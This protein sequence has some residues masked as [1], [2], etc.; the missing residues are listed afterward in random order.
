MDPEISVIF[1]ASRPPG[2]PQLKLKVKLLEEY[3]RK[4][5]PSNES[6]INRIW[7]LRTEQN[8]K[9]YNGSKFRFHSLEIDNNNG[10]VTFGL[11]LT[12]Y[13]D[14]IGTNWADNAAELL[15]SGRR[16]F[17]NSQA[18][19]SDALGVGAFVQTADDCVIFMRRSQHVGEAQGLW[20][21]PGGHAEPG[22]HN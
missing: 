22:V 9:L 11:G 5:L 12:G 19:M 7:G 3:N 1:A 20:D 13:K 17:S 6:N 8:P 21:I 14:F 15:E 2:I 16:D 4:T 10:E 18:Y